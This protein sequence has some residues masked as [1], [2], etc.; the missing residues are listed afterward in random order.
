[1]ALPA[2]ILC[3]F[4]HYSPGDEA[5]QLIAEVLDFRLDIFGGME[6]LGKFATEILVH[7]GN[8]G[9]VFGGRLVV[10]AWSGV[11]CTKNKR[12]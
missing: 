3:A 12:Q 9:V 8:K 4:W 1:L 10:F 2:Q 5:A 7:W 6:T 11:L